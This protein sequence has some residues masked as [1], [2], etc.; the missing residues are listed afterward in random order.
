MANC[1]Y[2]IDLRADYPVQSSRGWAALTIL[3]IK[4]LALIPHAFVLFFLN[5]A[6]IVVALVAQVAVAIKG[7]YPAGMHDFVSGVLRWNTRVTAFIFSLTDQYPPFALKPA[8]DYSVDV[9]IER[10]Q[11]SSRLYAAFTLVVEILF[12][13]FL[14]GVIWLAVW[15]SSRGAG[16]GASGDGS[17]SF[18]S[19]PNFPSGSYSGL[20]L[21]Q[22]AALPHL[23][24]LAF[25]SIGAFVVWLIV[26]WVILFGGRYPRSMYDFTAGYVRW[27]TRVTGYTLGLSDRYP[28]FTFEPSL[29]AP[30]LVGASSWPTAP[31][32]APPPMPMPPAAAPPPDM[33]P[34]P[35]PP[36]SPVP[37]A[38]PAP[39]QTP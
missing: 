22:I 17:S 15:A 30:A 10:P 32:P 23:I 9:V 31:P 11:S 2:P 28:P 38:P 20:V 27:Q 24:V 12:V 37:P 5:I 25:V 13:V 8:D 34:T 36:Q 29:V 39:P 26:Q 4:F 7:E 3:L 18:N 14:V 21:R 19:T 16:T 35:A 33:P 1:D 6:Q